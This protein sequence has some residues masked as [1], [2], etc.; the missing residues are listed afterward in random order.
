HVCLLGDAGVGQSTFLRCFRGAAGAAS[1]GAAENTADS[2]SKLTTK[3]FDERLGA[4]LESVVAL[5]ELD[6]DPCRVRFTDGVGGPF[7][8]RLRDT[9]LGTAHCVLLCFNTDS[10]E[11]LAHIKERWLPT[12]WASGCEAPWLLVGLRTDL[13][14]KRR[15]AGKDMS[16]SV[17]QQEGLE[18]A[19]RFG[20]YSYVEC[21]SYFADTVQQVVDDSLSAAGM[22]YEMQW[23][24]QPE[25]AF[26][27]TGMLQRAYVTTMPKVGDEDESS[28]A[29]LIH[30][31]L[32]VTDDPH[33]VQSQ[34]V[35]E[36]LSQLGDAGSR[37]H[38]YLRC[39]LMG[40]CLTSLDK[41]RTFVQLQFLNVSRN[42][43]RTLEPLGALRNLLHLNASHNCLIRTQC[44]TAPEGLET[45]DMS[46]NM[47]VELGE[48]K[49]HRYLREVNLRGNFISEIGPG[50]LGNGELR[51]LDLS[52]NYIR[53]LENL[54]DLDL[55]TL[56]LAQNRLTSLEGV[57]LL[58]KLHV[59][60]VQ[61]NNITSV[62]A[63]RSE[64]IPRLRKLKVADNRI[65][66]IDEL[67]NLASFS[68]LSDLN[69]QPNP[70]S[71]LPYYRAQVLHRLPRLRSL[72]SRV[73]SAEERVK[74]VLIF[75]AD[76]ETR[77]EIFE[78]LLPEETF[79]DRR[80]ITAEGI[81][82]MEL[83][84]F[85]R[86]GDAGPFGRDA[87]SDAMT[88]G[89]EGPPRTRLQQSKFRQ[90]VELARIGG[91]PEGVADFA[92]FPA[93]YM[94]FGVCDE[95]LP[96]LLEAVA[97]GGVEELLLG[98]ARISANG[99]RELV[100]FL[101]DTPCR[102]RHVDL[103]GCQAVSQLGME[104]VNTFPF[105][106][107]FSLE[108]GNCGLS[109]P[110]VVRLRNQSAEAE[111]ALTLAVEERTRSAQAVAAYVAKQETL[112]DF[113]AETRAGGA[114]PATPPA[115]YHPLKWRQGG[116][117]HA[118]ASL[119]NFDKA[120][121]KGLVQASGGRWTLTGKTGGI[122]RIDGQMF[123]LLREELEAV[124]L[125]W[126]CLFLE[127]ESDDVPPTMA[128]ASRQLPDAFC[129]A[130]GA[131]AMMARDNPKLLGFVL[132]EGIDPEAARK[133]WEERW[134]AEQKRLQRLKEAGVK[135]HDEGSLPPGV[136]SG[137]LMAHL[138]YLCQTLAGE[139]LK[140]LSHFDLK[141]VSETHRDVAP[142]RGLDLHQ[143]LAAGKVAIDSV[144]GCSFGVDSLNFK[145]QSLVEEPLLVTVR[146][147]TIFQHVD[148]SHR[149]NLLV[150]IDYVIEVPPRGSAQKYMHAYGMSSSCACCNGNAMN[151]TDV[152]L[153]DD[154][155]LASQALVWDHFEGIFKR[156]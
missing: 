42:S 66:Q 85:G 69:V 24:L 136:A 6:G 93:P 143:A 64:D 92:N 60:D 125:E 99:V 88:F 96:A 128:V 109:E 78:E 135:A 89:L 54:D 110:T 111:H 3:V 44:F 67:A 150:S 155:I 2:A 48:W 37:Q 40:V 114:P 79:V 46:Y 132:W 30:E 90:R 118:R 68:F 137:Q 126:G 36:N 23:Q 39:D 124:L 107:F 108:T 116:E 105:S 149:Q 61:H 101:K 63:L 1:G 140:P 10:A 57:A 27:D 43:L 55:R 139:V 122:T 41:I 152:Y 133:S 113:A 142:R 34:Q 22:F 21:S 83:Q 62:S 15:A 71:Q 145:L 38:A 77:R 19:Q 81:A 56:L 100:A 154:A 4:Q 70:V 47:I 80:L 104:L 25:A 156:E 12:L 65:S 129:A 74:T 76:V 11:S 121:P 20:A 98:A 35:Q 18:F 32:N 102:L 45:V 84:Q 95:D 9:A 16:C 115:L 87:N 13:R 53:H 138:S 146:R 51:M 59:L 141:K 153:D 103:A 26:A 91:E 7:F 33:P 17:S 131:D 29:W 119:K 14:E 147:G 134:G 112:E 75:G 49:V 82:E 94:G 31:R 148:W 58:S 86:N 5:V 73:V 144:L 97:E 106:K 117:A 28:E 127:G 130:F 123:Q 151:L 8:R 72:D 50:L 120:N 52:E